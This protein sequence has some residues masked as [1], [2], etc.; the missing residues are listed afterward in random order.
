MHGDG[1]AGEEKG[2]CRVAGQ[3]KLANL[4]MHDLT[5]LKDVTICRYIAHSCVWHIEWA[6][7]RGHGACHREHEASDPWPIGTAGLGGVR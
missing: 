5:S 4:E 6:Q 7:R 1:G 3:R 2:G